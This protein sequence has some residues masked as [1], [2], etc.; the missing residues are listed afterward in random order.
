MSNFGLG[1]WKM[2]CHNG[3]RRQITNTIGQEFKKDWKSDC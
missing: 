2:L 1:R 3:K